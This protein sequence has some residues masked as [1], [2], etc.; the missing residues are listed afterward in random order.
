[1]PSEKRAEIDIL[2]TKPEII[3]IVTLTASRDFRT[4][5]T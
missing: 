5:N 3:Y 1:M 4:I 2:L